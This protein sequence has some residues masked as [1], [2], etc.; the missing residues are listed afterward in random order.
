MAF[1]DQSDDDDAEEGGTNKSDKY[2]Q[3][4]R[5]EKKPYTQVKH[6]FDI[7]VKSLQQIPILDKF[8]RDSDDFERSSKKEPFKSTYIQNVAM[9]Y[10][11]PLDEDEVFES[12]YIRRNLSSNEDHTLCDFE[13]SMNTVHTYKISRSDTIKTHL[14]KGTT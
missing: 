13:V 1:S 5:D 9:K 6:V 2:R 4:K 14:K 3:R 8:I 11:F 7:N 10:S 12:D